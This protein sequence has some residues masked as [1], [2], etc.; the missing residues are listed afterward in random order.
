[1]TTQNIFTLLK[2][3]PAEIENAIFYYIPAP[4]PVAELV[5]EYWNKQELRGYTF[6]EEIKDIRNAFLED[7]QTEVLNETDDED[8]PE[9][10]ENMWFWIDQLDKLTPFVRKGKITPDDW[11]PILDNLNNY[12]YYDYPEQHITDA[13]LPYNSLAVLGL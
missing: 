6:I 10:L 9:K 12:L 5:K 4:N 13:Y 3:L 8:L 2:K 1:M 11:R 7:V